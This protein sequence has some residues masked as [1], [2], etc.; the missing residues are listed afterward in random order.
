[1]SL[2]GAVMAGA[3]IIFLPFAEGILADKSPAFRE[4]VGG[5]FLYSRY[6]EMSRTS[7]IPE[8]K[9]AYGLSQFAK[10]KQGEIAIDPEVLEKLGNNP[11]IKM[12]L[13]DETLLKSFEKKDFSKIFMNPK[14]L[15][16]FN[17]KSLLKELSGLGLP[18][19]VKNTSARRGPATLEVKPFSSE[20]AAIRLEGIAYS[21][22]SATVIINGRIYRVGSKCMGG[23]VSEITSQ[24]ITLEFPDGAKEYSVG[25]SIP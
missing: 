13:Q 3:L 14:I 6:T 9:I 12:I 17:D 16:L 4:Y 2:N 21:E 20:R 8:L 7:T 18:Q 25:D 23:V 15:S 5:S 19:K 1:G 24:S 22:S 11:R 10:L